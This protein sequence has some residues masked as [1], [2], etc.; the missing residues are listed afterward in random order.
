MVSL[1]Y[2]EVAAYAER[3]NDKS[4]KASAVE[5]NID[6]DESPLRAE[7]LSSM[8]GIDYDVVS[9]SK[10]VDLD[11]YKDVDEEDDSYTIRVAFENNRLKDICFKDIIDKFNE[12]SSS[13][14][15]RGY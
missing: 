12:K 4:Q 6:P 9:V 8:A 1:D 2:D 3:E 11:K 10:G 13:R 7:Q 15:K 14:R 5:W